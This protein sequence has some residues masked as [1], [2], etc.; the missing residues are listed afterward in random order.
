[1]TW[2]ARVRVLRCDSTLLVARFVKNDLGRRHSTANIIPHNRYIRN[3]LVNTLRNARN[4]EITTQ[5]GE[6][7]TEGTRKE[8]CE[9]TSEVGIP[10]AI[11]C[12]GRVDGNESDVWY[13]DC[14]SSE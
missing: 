3:D 5:K 4:I 12:D 9:V 7:K 8:D 1:V 6:G 13:L 10:S 11:W 2:L 14:A